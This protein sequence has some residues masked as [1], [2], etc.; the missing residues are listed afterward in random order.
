[1]LGRLLLQS[2]LVSISSMSKRGGKVSAS[3]ASS[4][5]ASTTAAGNQI[6]LP[7][8][9]PQILSL[10]PL[11]R[12]VIASR[13]SRTIKS[14]YVA[15]VMMESEVDTGMLTERIAS[16]RASSLS[17]S[18][19]S[20]PAKAS[21]QL[22]DSVREHM[23]MLEAAVHLA[24]APSLDCSGMVVPGSAVWMTA[25]TSATAKTSWTI[26]LCEELRTEGPIR[27]GYHPMLAENIAKQLLLKNLL[28]D[29]LGDLSGHTL[30]G[31]QTFGASRV[32]F[33]LTK[34]A[35]TS[36]EKRV[37]PEPNPKTKRA[38]SKRKQDQQ[39]SQDDAG[40]M[41]LVEVKNVVG[42]DYAE[43]TVPPS[44]SPVGVYLLPA[45]GKGHKRHAIFPVGASSN[46]PGLK[47]IVS[48]R[49]IKVQ[50]LHPLPKPLTPPPPPTS[51]KSLN[52]INFSRAAR[53]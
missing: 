47:G 46:K 1:M 51:T 10:A 38:G 18:S 4:S 3:S 21:K 23:S 52:S 25:A 49:A 30:K 11:R 35:V 36:G 32:D 8:L 39:V 43:G 14:P 6:Q 41:L 40:E 26:Q 20:S 53:A 45:D 5:I 50:L 42:A 28:S 19:T 27:V 24:H 12:A 9:G 16:I 44:R 31:Q 37:E 22:H 15:D 13:P 48:D 33:V 7:L 17:G 2:L 29:S 34:E